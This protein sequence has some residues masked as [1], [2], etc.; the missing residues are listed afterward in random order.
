MTVYHTHHILPKHMGGGD[1]PENLIELTVEEHAQA[2]L[3]LYREH[4]KIQDLIAY[5]MLSGQITAAEA[6]RLAQKYRDT[7]YMQ[8]EEYRKKMSE[9]KKG[10][11]P[12]NKGK[13]GV[14][15]IS[16]ETRR[17]WSEIRKGGRNPNAKPILFK[18]E[19]FDTMKEAMRKHGISK[20]LLL[21][22]PEYQPLS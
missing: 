17:K 5:R 9:A 13:K 2:H 20:Y 19:R 3:D 21:K 16:D 14:Q 6:T 15:P 12:W 7:S 11:T 8:T 22:H 4:G 10:S 18:G 1:E